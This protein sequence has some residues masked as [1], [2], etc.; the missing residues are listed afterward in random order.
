[1]GI[2]L[3][4]WHTIFLCVVL[5][6]I[7]GFLNA[8]WSFQINY[9]YNR[10]FTFHKRLQLLPQTIKPAQFANV[11]FNKIKSLKNCTAT[12]LK[13]ETLIH[14]PSVHQ[15]YCCVENWI[16]IALASRGSLKPA[17]S[18]KI[19]S[20]YFRYFWPLLGYHFQLPLF[21]WRIS[22]RSFSC[23]LR[24]S[25]MRASR[26]SAEEQLGSTLWRSIMGSQGTRDAIG[27]SEKMQTR[28]S[29]VLQ[30]DP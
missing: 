15:A 5:K 6:F 9:K 3:H 26:S 28:L 11:G 25:L 23:L 29:C 8:P 13:T 27:R 1:M 14:A 2:T 30:P 10:S 4:F 12:R 7:Y 18:I 19:N 17:V 20:Y 16:G 24:S 22:S 21:F